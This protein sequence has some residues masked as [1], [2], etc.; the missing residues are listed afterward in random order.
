MNKKLILSIF[1]LAGAPVL[2]SAAGEARLLRFPATN[3]K[4]IVFSYAGDLYKVPAA[5]GEAQRLTSHVGYEMFPRFSP[6]GKTIAFTG[7]YDGNTEVYTMPATGGEPLR[8]TYT[9]TNSR[10]DLGDRMGPNNIVMTWTPDG[11]RI[12]Y[13]NRISDGFSGKLFTVDKEGGL[14]EAIPLPEGGFCSYSP[15]GKQLAYNRVMREFRTWKYYKGGMADDIWVYNPNSKTVENITNNVAQDIFPMW[16]G[17]E[18][19]FLSDRDRIMNIF[20][21]NTKTKQTAKV[22]DFTEYDVKFPSASGNTIVFENGGYIY[23]MDAAT[24]KAEKVNIT[25]ASDNIYA[26]TDLKDGA[27]YVTAAS[28]SPDGA[29]MVVTS[30]GEVFNLP[31]EKGVTKN[32][33]R[34]PGAHDR[35]A[36]WSPDGTQIAYISDAT[37]E[38]ELYL[39][40]AAG[41]EPMQLTHKND[42]YIR[43]FKW[44]P[45]SK[46]IVYMDRKNRVNLLDVASGKVSL[47]LQ[48]PM[49]VPGGVTFSPDSEWLT[50][51]R[52]GK[53]EINVVYVYN[54]AEKKEYPVTDKWYNSSSPVFS[55]DGKYLIFSS[56]RDFNPTYGSLEWN[57]VYN[58]MY[59][60]YIA[61]LSKDTSSPFMQ[62]DAEVAASNA[63]PKSGDKKPA[64]KKEVAD[65]SLVKFDPD[66][67]TDRIVRLPLSPSYYGNF[68]SDGNKVYYWGRGGTKMYDLVSQK[69]ESIA[70]GASMDVTYDGKKALFFKGRQIYV[71]NLPSGKTELTTPVNLSNMKITVDYPKEWAQIFDEAWRAYRDGFYQESMHGVDWKAIKEKYAVLLPYVK[72]RLDLNYIIGE[73]IGELNCGHAY[74]NPGETE[75]PK[76]INTGLLGAE[77]TRDKSGFFRLEKIFPGASWSKEL[78]SPLTEPGVD[79][80]AGEYIVAI[81]GVPTNTVKDMYSLLVGKA[82]IPT[83]ISLNA[84]PQLSGARKVVISPLANEYPLIHY[85]WVQDNIKK[86]DQASNGRIGYI[87]IPD[88]GPE[89]LNEFARYFYPQLDKEGLII[90]DRANGGGNVSPMILERLSREPYRL[91]MGRGTSHV[92]TVPDAVQVGPKVCLINKYSASDGDLFPW[93]FRAL[94]LG[95][96]IGTRTWGG[97]VGISGSLPYMD[98]TD[99]RVPFFTSYDP[100]TGQ[101]IIEN[102]GVDPDILIDNDPVKEW[103]GEDQQLNRAIEEVMKQLQDRKPLAPV[104]APRDFSK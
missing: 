1:V 2:L 57:H 39:Q 61:L 86:V 45:D 92:G 67:I 64:D 95:K 37:G 88:M 30:R 74:V 19:F 99:I 69:E 55:A 10:D 42:T 97:I 25:L 40:N 32:I 21:Y 104:P 11:Q 66:G 85:N 77:I 75:Q 13:R 93:G 50:Y 27:N 20:V 35:D 62:K 73:M 8:V 65:A 90:D 54:I 91:T 15:D 84:K 82:E 46:K 24:R 59:G 70:D 52:M 22:T 83:E 89:G 33:T 12:V 34:S 78:R 9:A 47:L 44:S 38:T 7:Q 28:L 94:G 76:R 49:G 71:T 48:D 81:D 60:V 100:K 72:T 79:V 18:I 16:I 53:N 29:R 63:T 17:D 5:G 43:G 14:S 51:T 31:V 102:H 36:Q 26:R 41:G 58:N 103:N 56:A 23:K 68:Y 101:W 80:K 98:G 3:G 96:L 6:D 87:Y 4:E